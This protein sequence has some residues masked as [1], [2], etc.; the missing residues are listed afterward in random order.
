[1]HVLTGYSTRPASMKDAGLVAELIRVS[2][3][4]EEADPA[5]GI[6]DVIEHWQRPGLDLESDTAL[7][8]AQDGRIAGFA[9]AWDTSE[10]DVI[11]GDA[12]VH[13]DQRGH[14]IGAFLVSF[15]IRR[16][17]EMARSHASKR[18]RLR[19]Y[20]S[21]RDEG[22]AALLS[23]TGFEVIRHFF[24]MHIDLSEGVEPPV[25]PAGVHVRTMNRGTDEEV[26][27]RV[28]EEAFAEHWGRPSVPFDAFVKGFLGRSDFDPTLWFLACEGDDVVG[29][30]YAAIRDGKRPWVND[31]GVLPKAR[32]RGIG[33]ALLLHA[34]AEFTRR[35]FSSAALN[36]DASNATGATRL[37]ERA[38]M[39]MQRRFDCYEKVVSVDG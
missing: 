30:L 3:A 39:K 2:D 18:S 24:H 14:G 4:A 34:F 13:P 33:L 1:M 9:D 8:F 22:A 10:D 28:V 6:D 32:K 15:L 35:G 17:T 21:S 29:V 38:G 5:A 26:V 12:E 16:A 31:L 36:V 7:V 20:I 11:D 23:A 19:N 37:Y 27:H 25:W